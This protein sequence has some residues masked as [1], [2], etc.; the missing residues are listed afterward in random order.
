MA[1]PM[2]SICDAGIWLFGKGGPVYGSMAGRLLWEKSP[3]RSASVGTLVTCV[4]PV[5]SRVP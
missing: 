4:M 3:V 2:G 1:R 5:L